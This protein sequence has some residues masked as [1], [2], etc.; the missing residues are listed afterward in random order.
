MLSG[1]CCSR[2]A[3]ADAVQVIDVAQVKNLQEPISSA[4][5]GQPLKNLTNS[6][7]MSADPS[8]GRS[9][10]QASSSARHLPQ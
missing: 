5:G 6:P 2:P 3:I 10:A 9:R 1:L 8:P 7:V 4:G